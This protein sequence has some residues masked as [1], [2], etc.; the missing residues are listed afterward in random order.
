[1]CELLWRDCDATFETG[2]GGPD[3]ATG[4]DGRI[5][6]SRPTAARSPPRWSSTRWGGDGSWLVRGLLASRR[7]ADPRPRGPP[8]RET[9][10][11]SRSGWTAATCLAG[12]GW[13]FPA[14]EEVRVGRLLIRS[15]SSHVREGTDLPSPPTRLASGSATRATGSRTGC[16]RRP[17][18]DVFFA[19]DSA[20]HCLPL[21]AEG[22]RTALYY[23]VALGHELRA[24]VEGRSTRAQAIAEYTRPH[25]SHTGGGSAPA[26]RARLIPKIPSRLLGAGLSRLQDPVGS[27]T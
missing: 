18:G 15:P 21:T 10:R 26:A 16:A 7:P 2:G 11:S 23:G 24:V 27:S 22:I 1:M 6:R 13:S 5:S 12:Y 8:H 3:A 17:K 19:G 25:D 20:G 9:A 14:G 4:E